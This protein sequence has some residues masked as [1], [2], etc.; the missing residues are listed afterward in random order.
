MTDTYNGYTNWATWNMELWMDNDELI[1][2]ER[3]L[4][5]KRIIA[6]S[7]AF[8][9]KLIALKFFPIGTPDMQKS[10][11]ALINWEEIATHWEA[12]SKETT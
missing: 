12:E 1:C 3:L 4:W 11:L 9:A 6:P 7:L 2:K 5:W 8:K 10:D